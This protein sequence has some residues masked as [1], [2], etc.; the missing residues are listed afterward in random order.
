[1]SEQHLTE[2]IHGANS[3][4]QHAR[5]D[6]IETKAA[7]GSS[8]D[9]ALAFDEF[10]RAF[11][12]FKA[13]NEERIGQIEKRLSADVLTSEKLDRINTAIDEHKAIVDE[14]ALKSARPQLG[15]STFRS[16]STL[17]H[18]A[19]FEAYV[20]H[21]EANG[22]HRLEEKALSVG[23]GPD[24]G[25]LVPAETEAAV[26]RGVKNI[27]PIRAIAGNRVVSASVYKKPF[28]ITG[29][30][31]G[32]VAETATRPETNSPTLAE[33]TFPT[34]EL[35]AMPSATQTLLDDSAVN[36]DEWL[37]EEVQIAF[38]QQEGTAFVSG[39]GTNKPKG[40]LAYTKV[41]NGSWSWGNIGYIATGTDGA[42]DTADPSDDL[43]DF[44]YALKSEY[45]ANAHWVMNR[46]TQATIRKFKDADGNYIWQPAERAD[47]SPTLM[48][49]PVTE[50]EDMP[51][52]ASGSYSIAF[53]DFQRGYLV[54]DRAG[55]RVLRDPYSAKPYVLF[56]TTKRVGGGVQDFDAI[57]L[58]K[59]GT[60]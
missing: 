25:Y 26:I 57:K 47:L 12:A 58:L 32:W 15:A 19:A 14:L 24:G 5:V 35:Y 1:M 22:L 29:P 39:D 37:A 7:S 45:R 51:N 33:L 16:T 59:F 53:G 46:A 11:E 50:S 52:I 23:S 42:F 55:I 3:R 56:Y 28:A 41:A 8:E 38:A 4:A 49:Y 44:I 9:V 48:N 27:S 17:Q 31:T 18:K 10:M 21:G 20:R 2:D 60:S 6:H 43:I 54:V 13:T 30:S 40:F 34:M 36:I